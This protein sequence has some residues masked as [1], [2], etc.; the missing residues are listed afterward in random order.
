MN[1]EYPGNLRKK[2]YAT[3][4]FVIVPIKNISKS[5]VLEIRLDRSNDTKI[6][7]RYFMV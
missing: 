4:W 5:E 6:V 7:V 1:K 2:N 3:D